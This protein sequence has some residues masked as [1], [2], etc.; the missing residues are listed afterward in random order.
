M[1]GAGTQLNQANNDS[2]QRSGLQNIAKRIIDAGVCAPN[3]DISLRQHYGRFFNFLSKK[4][5]LMFCKLLIM[6][7]A[8][9]RRSY[10]LGIGGE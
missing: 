2:S 6:G 3:R 5:L 8:L 10:H 4:G 1:F 7:E 9:L